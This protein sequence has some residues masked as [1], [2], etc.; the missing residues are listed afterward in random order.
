MNDVYSYTETDGEQT[1]A[2]EWDLEKM[3]EMSSNDL[4]KIFF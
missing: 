1:E 2:F 4:W 3:K